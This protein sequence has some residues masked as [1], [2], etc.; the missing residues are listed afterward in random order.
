[1]MSAIKKYKPDV[2]ALGHDQNSFIYELSE[3]LNINKLKTSVITIDG[4]KPEI[5]K[6]SKLKNL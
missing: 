1:M 6:S 5:Y 4:Y 2:V 3:Y